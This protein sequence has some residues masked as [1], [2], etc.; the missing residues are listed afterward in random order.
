M[1]ILFYTYLILI[2]VY[3]HVMKFLFYKYILFF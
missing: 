3:E 2:F 1:I